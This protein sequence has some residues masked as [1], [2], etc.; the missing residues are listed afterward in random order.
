MF[1]EGCGFVGKERLATPECHNVMYMLAVHQH[2][3]FTDQTTSLDQWPKVKSWFNIIDSTEVCLPP[4][5]SIAFRIY[6]SSIMTSAS[7]AVA[8]IRR[9][10]QVDG[11]GRKKS[12]AEK[13]L[14]GSTKSVVGQSR[15]YVL[16]YEKRNEKVEI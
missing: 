6:L 13:Q 5:Q 2:F 4:F 12:F 15:S 8:G 11:K 10:P 16:L 14:W 9:D 7:C 1:Q 3:T